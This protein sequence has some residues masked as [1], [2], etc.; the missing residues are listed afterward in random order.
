[1]IHA[2][3]SVKR[4]IAWLGLDGGGDRLFQN[5]ALQTG[6]QRD[7]CLDPPWVAQR[8]DFRNLGGIA[9]EAC[10]QQKADRFSVVGRVGGRV[11]EAGSRTAEN[12]IGRQAGQ[13]EDSETSR[14]S[15]RCMGGLQRWAQ[16]YATHRAAVRLTLAPMCG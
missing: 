16:G 5:R 15:R 14:A 1:L 11:L 7:L 6:R 13:G 12:V 3:T 9:T 2:V 10:L 4:T 8:L